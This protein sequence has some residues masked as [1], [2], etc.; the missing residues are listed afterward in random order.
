MLHLK[1][2]M[3]LAD[4][5]VDVLIYIGMLLI[6]FAT[7]YPFVNILAISFN[8]SID[9]IRGGIYLWPRRFTLLNYQSVFSYP[10]ILSA[11]NMSVLRTVVGTTLGVLST[12]MVSYT[13]SRKDFIARKFTTFIFLLTMY[14]SGGLIP[15]FFLIRSLGLMNNFW[16][17]ILPGLIGAWNVIVM[18]SFI[19]GL[20][21]SL[22]ESAKIDGAN[23][24]IIVFRIIMPLC[25][26]VI[27]TI[28]LFVAV[29]QWNS[30]F[31]T[32]IYAS[33]ND[34]LNTLQFELMRILQNTATSMSPDAFRRGDILEASIVTPEAIRATITIVATAPI[35]FVYPFIQ[36]YFVQGITLG[37]VKS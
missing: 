28:S 34:S 37:A 1:K 13:L 14:F 33:A 20:P 15:E 35:L 30:W 24:L 3:S 5:T 21:D 19:E 27:A 31:D 4:K 23:D 32:F 6:A 36:K 29:G 10:Q 22:Q 2:H 25:M 8:D 18:R 16:V 12:F 26:P 11:F 7:L 17:Y 9:T